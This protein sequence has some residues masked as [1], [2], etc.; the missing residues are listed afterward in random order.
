MRGL[1]NP[2]E[3]ATTPE[4]I[5]RHDH[6]VRFYHSDAQ[7]ADCVAEFV[8]AGLSQGDVA[9]LIVTPSHRD[10]IADSFRARGS[11]LIAESESGRLALVDADTALASFMRG[12][13]PDRDLFRENIGGL[14]ERISA[15]SA[16]TCAFGEMVDVLWRAGNAAG[17][18]ELEQLWNDLSQELSF[19]LLCGYG[20]A[21]FAST[22]SYE[23]FE[24][25]CSLH[26]R[27]LPAEGLVDTSDPRAR[28]RE[29]ARLQQRAISLE[30][31]IERRKAAE[32]ELRDFIDNAVEG[33]HWVGGDG[34]ILWAN[35]AE[36]EMLGY[37]PEEYIGKNIVEFHAER[38]VIDDI[39]ARLSRGEELHEYESRLKC[40]NGEVRDVTINS[41]VRWENG[42]FSHTRCFTRDITERKRNEEALLRA[43]KEAE[44]AN[45]VKSDF[46]AVMSHELRTPL[47]GIIGYQ[48]L[49]AEE[50]G[51][52]LTTSQ[53]V[54]LD[55]IKVGADQLVG[56]IDQ[57]LSL[58]RIE[59]GTEQIDLG[60][61]ETGAA[62]AQAVAMVAP[63]A[64]R[65]RIEL[66]VDVPDDEVMCQTDRAKLNQILLN[67][68]SNAV[69]F[70]STGSVAARVR[71][72]GGCV[73]IEVTDT[74]I[75]IAEDDHGRIF[76]PFVQLDS[77]STRKHG[78]AGLG[79]SVSR[80]LARLMGG[81]ITVRS[82]AGDG[83]TFTLRVPGITA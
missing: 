65:K 11:D 76:D 6:R 16:R 19:S 67:L 31:E 2:V 78:G 36:L 70:T 72:S 29:I 61:V 17:A 66:V 22:E 34:T 71:R 56:L 5:T 57:V 63:V 82:A 69:K 23:Q 9:V 21:S 41:N 10:L 27:V 75:G 13:S 54:Y 58:S 52:P 18:I 50:V 68:L 79:L 20:L 45:K 12:V 59:A 26:S 77:S 4:T 81:E 8:M 3:T 7:L 25:I 38:P 62:V 44:R 80:N 24:Q 46:L 73:E 48:D 28:E 39:L 37:S 60:I 74:G 14:I 47:N 51:G 32:E 40:K 30:R 43:K 35:R 33:L 64:A 83:S 15:G 1:V 49:L 42:R 55:R 53:R